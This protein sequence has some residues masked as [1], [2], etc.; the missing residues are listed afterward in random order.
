MMI[1][2]NGWKN[3]DTATAIVALTNDTYALR[4]AR[5]EAKRDDLNEFSLIM[6]GI[7]EDMGLYTDL[8]PYKVDWKEV[9]EAMI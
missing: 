7:I 8:D 6:T 9:M 1:L 4:I 2:N 5:R 3:E